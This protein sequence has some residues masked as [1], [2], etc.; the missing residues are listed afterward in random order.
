M[1]PQS[2]VF[3]VLTTRRS[4]VRPVVVAASSPRPLTILLSLVLALSLSPGRAEPPKKVLFFDDED[5]HHRSGTKRVL[6]ALKKQPGADF[7]NIQ[8]SKGSLIPGKY[9]A[10]ESQIAFNSVAY[11]PTASAH[12]SNGEYVDRRFKIWYQA[13]ANNKSYDKAYRCVVSYAVSDDGLT[14]IKP[15]VNSPGLGIVDFK[16]DACSTSQM[17]NIGGILYYSK[18][19]NCRI[20]ETNGTDARMEPPYLT[21][22]GTGSHSAIASS[23]TIHGNNIVLIGSGGYGDRFGVS[24]VV[25]KNDPDPNRR[26][27][28]IHEDFSNVGSQLTRPYCNPGKKPRASS[29]P[30][31][32]GLQLAFSPDGIHWTKYTAPGLPGYPGPAVVSKQGYGAENVILPPASASTLEPATNDVYRPFTLNDPNS[33]STAWWKRPLSMADAMD[34]FYDPPR[35][36]GGTVTPGRYMIYG[37]MWV[38]GPSPSEWLTN[39][40]ATG[41][42]LCWKHAMGRITS[43]NFIDWSTPEIL[44]T[45]DY[46]DEEAEPGVNDT[47]EF[48][49]S[50]VFTYEGMYLSF[51]QL[52][53]HHPDKYFDTIDLELMSSRDGRTWTRFRKEDYNNVEILPRIDAGEDNSKDF[54]TA[55]LFSNN[56]PIVVGDMDGNGVDDSGAPENAMRIYYG[57]Y[58]N[59]SGI[60]MAWVKQDRLVGLSS[61]TSTGQVTLKPYIFTSGTG[62]LRINAVIQPG[63][64]VAAELLDSRGYLVTTHMKSAAIVITDT[65]APT[66]GPLTRAATWTSPAGPISTIPS[67]TY[68]VRIHLNNAEL[69]SVSLNP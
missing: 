54:D 21:T 57:A 28:M 12:P 52:W 23:G 20:V 39:H 61:G 56:T 7:D 53:R 40:P 8:T 37:K 13:Y 18:N 25:D 29:E 1:S 4:E 68:C 14:W 45:V 15:G 16:N 50:P 55:F 41:G 44:T 27:K 49:T 36:N 3:G 48:H 35:T 19:T 9:E 65:T 26:Y 64:S 67:G 58:G 31:G 69:F 43:T 34:V 11:D 10:W 33:A 66:G 17:T 24:V 46:K 2:A 63:G 42:P 51:N 60:G 30:T 6:H 47:I 22:T 5:V 62:T 38:D 32:P 59:G